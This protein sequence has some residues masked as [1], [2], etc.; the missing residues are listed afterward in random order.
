MRSLQ[1]VVTAP[2][3]ATAYTSTRHSK[4]ETTPFTVL[5]VN[6]FCQKTNNIIGSFSA[7]HQIYLKVIL[8][9]FKHRNI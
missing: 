2:S 6:L 1:I 8:M 5:P 3:P 7:I 9:M 4:P